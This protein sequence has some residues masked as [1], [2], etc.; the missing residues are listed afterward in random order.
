MS[1][2]YSIYPAIGVARVGNAPDAF[3]I[4]PESEG[5][6]PTKPDGAPID[7]NGFRDSNGR[8][9]RQA[10]RFRIYRSI[11]G[12]TPEEVTLSTPGVSSIRW[13]VHLANKKASW[14]EFQ[15]SKGEDGYA[16][17]HPLRNAKQT[18]QAERQALVIDPGPRTTFGIEADPVPFSRD[19]IPHGYPGGFPPET[20]EP[21]SID[22]LGELRTD[23]QGRLLVLGGYGRSG[24]EI[25]PPQIAQYANNDGWWDDTSDGPVSARVIFE[26]GDPDIVIADAWALVGPPGYAPQIPNLVTLYDTIFDIVTRKQGLRPDIFENGFWKSGPDGY[27]PSFETDIKPIFERAALYP[28]VTAIPPKPHTFDYAKLGAP[29]PALSGYRQYFLDVLRPPGGENVLV[30]QTSGRTA[31]PYLAGDDALGAQTPGVV[32]AATSKYLRLT[33]T[34]YF[35]LQQWVDGYFHAGPEPGVHPGE[36]ITRGVLQNC[37]GGAF[38]PGI[39]M[40]WISRNPDIYSGAFRIKGR[41][42]LPAPLSLGFAPELGLEP[43]DVTRYMAVP[44]QA[45]FNE[46]SSQPIEGRIIWWWPAQRPEFVYLQPPQDPPRA[47]PEETLALQVAWIGSDY[48]QNASDYIAFADDLDMVELWDQLGFVYN[49]GTAQD[50]KFFEVARLLPREEAPKTEPPKF[51]EAERDKRRLHEL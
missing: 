27:Q 8:L 32:T 19:T 18:S 43:G 36:A 23:A 50:P 11:D 51:A 30:P 33:D 41:A 37:V 10:A 31:M 1:T 12:G 16:P 9:L 22:T 7:Q 28:W 17:N 3:Y 49:F 45:D 5:A 21:Y 29:D 34:Q 35:F 6:L 44:W 24:S 40:T 47:S 4:A 39:E 15:T 46:C 42:D 13:T 38:S 20:L 25:D 2:D 26:N 48:N 14:Y